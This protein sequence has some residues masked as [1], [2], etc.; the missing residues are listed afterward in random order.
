MGRKYSGG[1][2]Q[3][4]FESMRGEAK[5]LSLAKHCLASGLELIK[6]ADYEESIWIEVKGRRG[7]NTL[8]F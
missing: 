4:S 1:S 7:R 3:G 8:F 5:V 6:D 2:R